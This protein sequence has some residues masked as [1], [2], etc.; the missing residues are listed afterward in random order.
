[1]SFLRETFEEY[2]QLNSEQ[3]F[4][5]EDHFANYLKKDNS[6]TL[7]KDNSRTFL[8]C[9]DYISNTTKTIQELLF[10]VW[11]VFV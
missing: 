5:F 2:L 9:L 11:T 1:M 8:Q 10:K 3:K 4:V 7:N 6:K